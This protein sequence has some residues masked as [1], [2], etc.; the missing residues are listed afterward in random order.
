MKTYHYRQAAPHRNF[1]ESENIYDSVFTELGD[2]GFY[3]KYVEII[4]RYTVR[5]SII[6]DA[7]CGIGTAVAQ[8]SGDRKLIG[9]D[10]SLRFLKE[11]K[12]RF[13]GGNFIQGDLCNIPMRDNST[14]F[15]GV[16][17][18]AE[19]LYNAEV[20]FGEIKRI[21]KK[22]GMLFIVAH[23]NDS[24]LMPLLIFYYSKKYGFKKGHRMCISMPELLAA[25]LKHIIKFTRALISDKFTFK[26]GKFEPSLVKYV[27][28]D[29][30]C[31]TSYFMIRH[32]K[33]N[34]FKIIK[35]MAHPA[36]NIKY[37]FAKVFPYFFTTTYIIAEKE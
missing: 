35:K 5:K 4:R 20:F 25:T 1:Y 18:V 8:L 28:D 30:I 26:Y 14:D 29:A 22:G 15:V 34:G 27:D 12:I 17:N 37:A 13:P 16:Y 10:W 36:V 6:L 23:N 3:K 7:G 21:L 11:A 24:P 32:F 19:H 31:H 9:V 2:S 33:N